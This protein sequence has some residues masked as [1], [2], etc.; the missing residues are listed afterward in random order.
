M[1][2]GRQPH[3]APARPAPP[4]PDRNPRPR[5]AAAVPRGGFGGGGS[6]RGGAGWA[7]GPS[8]SARHLSGAGEPGTCGARGGGCGRDRTGAEPS[9][10]GRGRRHRFGRLRVSRGGSGG[11]G[12][13]AAAAGTAPLEA[14]GSG[15]CF[16][17]CSLAP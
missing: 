16:M 9:G 13:S 1:A 5:P 3:T 10:K 17:G 2:A 15:S 4:C 14:G 12:G 8:L 11:L 6:G 7:A